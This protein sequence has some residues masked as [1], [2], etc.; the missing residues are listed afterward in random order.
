MAKLGYL[1]LGIMG[2]PMAR[3]LRRAGHDVW[4]WSHTAS[5]AENLAREEGAAACATPEEVA[6]NVDCL[7]LCVGDTE[8]SRK[9]L[10]GEDGV[11]AGARPG[12][13]VADASTISISDSQAICRELAAK[14]V[15]LL[16]APCTG[17]KLGADGGKLTFMVGGDPE[18]FE[19]IKPYFDPMGQQV[20]YCGPQG[21]GLR[22]K[23]SM[24]LIQAN[25]LQA[26]VEGIVLSTKAGVDPQ[27]MLDVINNTAAKCGLISFKAPYVFRRD[28][29]PHFSVKWM[30]KDMKLILEFAEEQKVPVPITG[31]TAQMYQ[32]A[33]ARGLEDEDFSSL[34]KV[35]EGMAGVE[36]RSE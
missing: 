9:V 21:S 27:L 11:I 28:F 5:K 22:V 14:G 35:L 29:D 33:M 6:R 3:N 1:G 25:V 18:V 2:F 15:H 30:H 19:G 7:F 8:M 4:V 31:V 20:F 12:L 36:V 13:A 24:N 16:D 23:L 17:S 34:I 26:F 32:A 10:L